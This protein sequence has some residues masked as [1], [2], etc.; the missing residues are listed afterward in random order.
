MKDKST[1]DK[2]VLDKKKVVTVIV[3][4]AIVIAMAIVFMIAFN[5]GKK[6]SKNSVIEQTTDTYTTTDVTNITTNTT[7]IPVTTKTKSQTTTKTPT[8]EKEEIHQALSP[9]V[10]EN[11]MVSS[12]NT[13]KVAGIYRMSYLDNANTVSETLTFSSDGSVIHQCSAN[14]DNG[15]GEWS[16]NGT[17]ISFTLFWNGSDHIEYET[18]TIVDGGIMW[19]SSFLEKIS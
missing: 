14:D 18:A 3:F 4:A 19:G 9:S 16:L 17:T 8:T 2:I 5:L 6:S 12:D 11:N 7:T 15:Y 13:P 10:S 1:S